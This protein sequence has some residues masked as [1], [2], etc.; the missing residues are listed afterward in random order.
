MNLLEK[1]QTV[2]N[3]VYNIASTFSSMFLNVYLFIY[4]GE[5]TLMCLY[6]IVR[7]GLFPVFFI[8]G[9][10]IIKKCSYA[11]PYSLGLSLN[12]AS[13]LYALFATNLFEIN[14]NFVLIGAIF[15]GIGDGFYWF[16]SNSC[17]Q[18]VSSPDTRAK[19][20][21]ATGIANY[22][23]SLLAP[24]AAHIIINNSSSDLKAYRIILFIIFVLYIF[25]LFISL[26]INPKKTNNDNNLKDAFSFKDKM[27]NDH[28]LAVIFY[29]FRNSLTLVVTGLLIFNAS[30]D[31]ETYSKLQSIFSLISVLSFIALTRSLDK[32]HIKSTFIFGTILAVLST[33]VLVLFN[34]IYGAIFFGVS[35][36]LVI[37]FFD[38]TYNYLSANIISSFK[39]D[40]VPRVVQRETCLS[41][42]RCVAMGL[43]ILCY[44]ILPEYLYLKVSVVLLSLSS[45]L[46][47]LILKKY[48]T[49]KD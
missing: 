10:K 22:L 37:P 26:S 20:I 40:M 17:S 47:Y 28:S 31:G 23:A 12:A 32:E 3:G 38:N 27:W 18:I 2:L 48:G 21:S 29:G 43:I 46:V 11:V 42:G 5:L 35:N 25:V 24:F 7:I 19:F 6:T 15:Q 14:P 1:R 41:I 13:L 4:T 34:N 36:A 49:K 30:K 33:S 8:I 44:Y 45:I 39:E 9:S 16:A